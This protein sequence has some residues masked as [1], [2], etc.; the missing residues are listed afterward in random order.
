MSR[1]FGLIGFPLTHSFSRK[2][3]TQ[4]F[5]DEGITDA[6]YELFEMEEATGFPALFERHPDLVGLN[7]TIPH[8]KAVIPLLQRLDQ[9]ASRVGAVNVILKESDGSLT[10]YN[11]D[12]AGF[13][14]SLELWAGDNLKNA[15]ALVLG[16]GGAAAAVKV[17]LEDLKIDFQQVSRSAGPGTITYEDLKGNSDVLAERRLI[18]NTTP[19]GTF[20]NTETCPDIDFDLVG[21]NHFLYDL[22]YNPAETL[23]MKR[24]RARGASVKNGYDMLVLQAERAWEI[25]NQK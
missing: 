22:V 8:K 10:G 4:K 23:F 1:L 5:L 17:A 7:V 2:Y 11:S 12:Y 15:K 18:I 3:F 24:G 9:S 16:T 20:P 13:L 25:W 21:A 6:A 19:L 14:R